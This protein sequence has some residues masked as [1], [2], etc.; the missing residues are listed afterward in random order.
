MQT[1]EQQQAIIARNRRVLAELVR[2]ANDESETGARRR[3]ARRALEHIS[4]GS[5][6]L[7]ALSGQMGTS[8]GAQRFTHGGSTATAQ[9][10]AY[11][12]HERRGYKG[13]MRAL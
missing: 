11:D 5:G 4:E 3:K 6:A 1:A 8:A 13:N 12:G 2:I 7:A 10:L 9:Q